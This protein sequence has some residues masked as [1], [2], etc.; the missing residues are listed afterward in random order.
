MNNRFV[1]II[2]RYFPFFA[3]FLCLLSFWPGLMRS[4]SLLQMQQGLSSLPPSDF[5]P[6]MMGFIWSLF[7][8]IYQGAGVLFVLHLALY[9]GAVALFANAKKSYWFYLVAI[10]P[11][12]FSYQLLVIK[13]ISF[14]NAYL[15]CAAWLHFYSMRKSSPKSLS[16]FGWLVVAFYGTCAAYQSIIALPWLCLW[17]SR[18]YWPQK[19]AKWIKKGI[20]VTGALA[21][22]VLI[23]NSSLTVP[24]HRIQHN[25]LYDLAGISIYLNTPLFPDYIKQHKDYD[26][27]R[28]KKL[29]N[30][31]RVDDL[32]FLSDSPVRMSSVPEELKAL[33]V[34]WISAIFS[35]PLAYFKH[36]WDVFYQQLT[37]SL[38][39]HPSDIKEKTTPLVIKILNWVEIAG[40]FSVL[41]LLMAYV[42]YFAIQLFFVYKGFRYFKRDPKYINL[43]FQNIMGIALVSSLFFIASAAE[44][45]YAYL[46][47][48]MFYFSLPIISE[49]K[50]SKSY[51]SHN[52]MEYADN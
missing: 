1:L 26:F 25:E 49:K 39:K 16:V 11:P 17:F 37:I 30:P 4:D 46:A 48:A 33:R 47:I 13:D 38:L 34:A 21:T 43:F 41:S 31:R 27:E 19:T 52:N 6:P 20:A 10:L 7:S 44:A 15:F 35:H 5:H 18:V 2:A 40:I 51:L 3:F 24:S 28:I 45:R 42:P 22:S 36:R 12:I 14:V 32:V 29:Y 50:M 23:F 9:W 8:K